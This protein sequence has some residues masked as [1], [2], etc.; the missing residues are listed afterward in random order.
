M[1]DFFRAVDDTTID[2]LDVIATNPILGK[3]PG[4][5]Q[6]NLAEGTDGNAREVFSAMMDTGLEISENANMRMYRLSEDF[7]D[8]MLPV[9]G[10]F[11]LNKMLQQTARKGTQLQ[12]KGG[13]YGKTVGGALS[14]VGDEQAA[15]RSIGSY[16][17]EALRPARVAV[18]EGLGYI[19]GLRGLSR[20]RAAK[21]LTGG[22]AVVDTMDEAGN[23]LKAQ[24]ILDDIG[25]PRL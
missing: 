20:S 18:D 9:K 23:V 6:K 14:A 2:D 17:G 5:V 15:Y 10:S 7:V 13:I 25:G 22:P 24:K 16:L 4:P 12:Q 3:L 11:V 19:P 1:D 21:Q 8:G